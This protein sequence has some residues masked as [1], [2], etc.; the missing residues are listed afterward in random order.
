MRFQVPQYVDI[1]DKIVGPLTLKQ[2]GI[3]F[4]GVLLLIPVYLFSDLSL[5]ITIALP[6]GAAAAAFAHFKPQ[7]K[8]L[9]IFILNAFQFYTG[10]QFWL[11]RREPNRKLLVIKDRELQEIAN[12]YEHSNAV[13]TDLTS[14]LEKASASIETEGNVVAEDADDP[15]DMSLEPSTS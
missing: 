12:L 11:W 10:G 14:S 8:P 4:S 1:Q 9:E 5:F 3:Y 7:G 13:P 2:F 6:I 15:L